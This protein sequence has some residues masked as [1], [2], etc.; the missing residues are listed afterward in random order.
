M[1]TTRL[2]GLALLAAIALA[3]C[4]GSAS[5]PPAT[6]A[7][8][9]D[10]PA[11]EAPAATPAETNPAETAAPATPGAAGDPSVVDAINACTLLTAAEV[12]AALDVPAEQIQP[13]PGSTALSGS[14]TCFHRAPGVAN[15]PQ[16]NVAVL[17]APDYSRPAE[18]S[19]APGLEDASGGWW[20]DQLTGDLKLEA[21]APNGV[22]LTLAYQD[23]AAGTPPT[24]AALVFLVPL[25]ATA[26]GR[27]P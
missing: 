14:R 20:L 10:A 4:G 21:V 13:M 8:V 23:T 3:A 5:A 9:T 24:D 26:L 7:P 27:L 22:R 1:T 18:P 6:S 16:V 12:A 25:A 11:T 19:P 2:A 17:A 15:G